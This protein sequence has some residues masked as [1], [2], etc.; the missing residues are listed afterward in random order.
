MATTPI[1][2]SGLT[3]EQKTWYEKVLLNRSLPNLVHA[4]WAQEGRSFSIPQHEGMTVDFRKF[5]SL[6]VATTPLTE[7]V[8]P[9]PESVTNTH[10][11]GTVLQ[12]GA[13][14]LY[15]DIVSYTT[16]DPVLTEFS[17]LLGEQA[18]YVKWPALN[19]H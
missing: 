17:E 13:Y 3:Y 7:G 12:Y 8:T 10:E 15:T 18:G 4:R 6:S 19:S 1:T 16:I 14:I 2:Y 5:A 11:T 9:S